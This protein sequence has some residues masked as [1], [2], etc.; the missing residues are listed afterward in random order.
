MCLFDEEEQNTFHQ[1]GTRVIFAID[2]TRE[3]A[4]QGL[5]PIPS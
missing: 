3:A 5:L 1:G 4:P 2:G